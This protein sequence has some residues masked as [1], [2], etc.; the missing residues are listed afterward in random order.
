MMAI[1]LTC[2][3]RL[4]YVD[5]DPPGALLIS[6]GYNKYS[7]LLHYSTSL[8]DMDKIAPVANDNNTYQRMNNVP[9]R[10]VPIMYVYTIRY[11]PYQ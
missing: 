5:Q 3:L 9:T 1:V 2:A 4:Q 11:L 10:T 7:E 8:T 6:F